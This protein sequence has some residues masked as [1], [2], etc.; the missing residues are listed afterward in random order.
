M[1]IALVEVGLASIAVACAALTG[2]A[3]Q[4][5]DPAVLGSVATVL[6]AG[7]LFLR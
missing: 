4:R 2:L 3:L 1:R 7:R 5:E 6:L